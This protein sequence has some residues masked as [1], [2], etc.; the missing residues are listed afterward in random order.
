VR[1]ETLQVRSMCITLALT[2][3]K[4]TNFND[5]KAGKQLLHLPDS[6]TPD[7]CYVTRL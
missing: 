3:A 6:H 2:V 1:S 7:S 4:L 5:Q